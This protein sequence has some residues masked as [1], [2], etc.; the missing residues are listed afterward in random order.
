MVGGEGHD[1]G[2]HRGLGVDAV[3]A[4]VVD[5]W[6]NWTYSVFARPAMA[7]FSA[8]VGAMSESTAI[9]VNAVSSP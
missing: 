9:R 7:D 1:E 5:S 3:A 6:V 8:I 2:R 4:H